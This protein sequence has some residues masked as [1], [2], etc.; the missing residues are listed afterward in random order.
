MSE[1]A[2]S[3]VVTMASSSCEATSIL[4]SAASSFGLIEAISALVRVIALI[5]SARSKRS[6]S[7]SVVV[8]LC[9]NVRSSRSMASSTSLVS[10]LR[11]RRAYSLRNQRPRAVSMTAA[12]I[13]S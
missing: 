1:V 3:V 6:R 7:A 8:A 2:F 12:A 4:P 11:L 13:A 5:M 10:L 9:S